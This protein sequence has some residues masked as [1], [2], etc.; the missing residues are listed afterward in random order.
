MARSSSPNQTQNKTLS[1][2]WITLGLI[3]GFILIAIVAGF[4]AYQFINGFVNS[5]TFPGIQ[6]LSGLSEPQPTPSTSNSAST[7]VTATPALYQS[8]DQPTAVA[9]DGASRITVLVMG[10]DFR[11]WQSGETPRSDTMIL[12]TMDPVNKTAAMFSIPRDMWVN[13]PGYDYMKINQAYFIGE[14]QRLPGGGAALAQKTVENFIGV[15]INYVAVIDFYTFVN[16]VDKIGGITI[17]IPQDTRVGILNGHSVLLKA[18]TDHLFGLEAL[19]Y[20]RDR[21]S[22]N[23]DFDRAKRQ[24]AV[25]IGIRNRV[26]KGSIW[27]GLLAGAPD[28]YKQFSSGIH[29]NMTLDE[30][31]K[32]A[33]IARQIP[34]D[35]ITQAVISPQMT[36]IT[37]SL[38]D[39][40]DVLVP[41]PDKIRTFRDQIFTPGVAFAPSLVDK[42]IAQLMKSEGAKVTVLNATNTEGLATRTSDYFKSLGM[43]VVNASNAQI[44]NVSSITVYTTKPYTVA[45]LA[46]IMSIPEAQ[47]HLKITPNAPADLE[48]YLGIDWARKNPMP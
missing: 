42:D 29:T 1:I 23:G 28:L 11:N 10:L 43:N 24:Q 45:D 25:I 6:G 20:A 31:I 19:G 16:F 34:P 38:G 3:V 35:Q 27:P 47:I 8:V 12:L 21:Y 48:V 37:K 15:P 5:W 39:N 40:L 14:S 32:L 13:I 41:I 4:A 17:D 22:E 46:K 33:L 30:A 36:I 18:G 44:T 2:N 7:D 9:W 26:L